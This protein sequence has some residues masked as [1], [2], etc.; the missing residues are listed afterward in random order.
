MYITGWNK[1][2]GLGE[3]ELQMT[4]NEVVYVPHY[5]S[6]AA[7]KR[8]MQDKDLDALGLLTV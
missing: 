8:Q 2:K 5:P 7:D 3:L 6:I 4:P 1:G